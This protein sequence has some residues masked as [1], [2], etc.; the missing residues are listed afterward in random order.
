MTNPF[1]ESRIN[2]SDEELSSK[3][4]VLIAFTMLESRGY[5]GFT[6]LIQIL[7]DP[8]V[9]LKIVRFMYGMEIKIPPLEEF[10]KC[11]Q[12]AMYT[13]CDMHKKVH[14]NL[15]AK[16]KDIRDLLNI[17]EKREQEL[18]EV[19][20]QWSQYMVKN[21]IDLTNLM[22]INREATKKRIRMTASGKKWTKKKY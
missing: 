20:D 7:N 17:D 4:M 12:A 1:N 3:E 5:P 16:P 6:Q 22:H 13:F 8:T 21:G 10:V 11:L 2:L 9:I 19:F 14:A 18:L 15:V